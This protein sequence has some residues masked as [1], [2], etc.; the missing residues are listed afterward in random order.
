MGGS[1][2]FIACGLAIV[3]AVIAVVYLLVV[4]KLI[5]K[6]EPSL[7]PPKRSRGDAGEALDKADKAA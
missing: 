3:P 2:F 5:S 1:L 4:K 6:V 7:R